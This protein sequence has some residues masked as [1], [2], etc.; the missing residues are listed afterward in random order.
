MAGTCH[1]VMSEVMRLSNSENSV[2]LLRYGNN[3]VTLRALMSCV[4]FYNN[5]S[6]G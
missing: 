4:P 2:F 3:A 1:E 6:P 5:L